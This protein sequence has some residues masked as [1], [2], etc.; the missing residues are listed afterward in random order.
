MEIN[1]LQYIFSMK[2][3]PVKTWNINHNSCD[4]CQKIKNYTKALVE[5]LIANEVLEKL[6]IQIVNF[7]IK[8]LLIAEKDVILIVYDRLSKIIYFIAI[9]EEMSI[10]RLVRLLRNNM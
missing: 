5:N 9:I 1:E 2:Q 3:P 8:L 10:R 4:L 7:I 6:W